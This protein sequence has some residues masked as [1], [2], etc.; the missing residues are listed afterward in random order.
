MIKKSMIIIA[1]GRLLKI[2]YHKINMK[3]LIIIESTTLTVLSNAA[4]TDYP[5]PTDDPI[6]KKVTS[7]FEGRCKE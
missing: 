6:Y 1:A 2:H 3:L 4:L 5:I 7:H